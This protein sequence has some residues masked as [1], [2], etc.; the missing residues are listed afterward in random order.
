MHPF[1]IGFNEQCR[2]VTNNDSLRI[3][4]KMFMFDVEKEYNFSSKQPFFCP[5]F[6]F[7]KSRRHKLT[8]Y[9]SL[10]CCMKCIT[11]VT[12]SVGCDVRDS[13]LS[14]RDRVRTLNRTFSRGEGRRGAEGQTDGQAE[15]AIIAGFMYELLIE[16]VVTS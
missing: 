11:S 6:F 7:I 15:G 16:S 12:T 8:F 10:F 13:K 9:F 3:A 5:I 1:G 2:Q 4:V 14:R